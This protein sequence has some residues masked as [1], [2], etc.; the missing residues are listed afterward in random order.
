MIP[1]PA[2]PELPVPSELTQRAPPGRL[3]TIAA[4]LG[5]RRGLI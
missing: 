3:L 2:P 1:V 4:A 5:G